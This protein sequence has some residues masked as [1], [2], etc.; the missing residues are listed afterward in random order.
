MLLTLYD[1]YVAD[2]KNMFTNSLKEEVLEDI[3]GNFFKNY[4]DI[5]EFPKRKIV[6]QVSETLKRV[7]KDGNEEEILTE[8]CENS[9][10]LQKSND[11]Y[12][13][14]HRTFYEYYVACKY[15]NDDKL[16]DE[17]INKIDN[18]KWEEVIR[19]YAGHIDSEKEDSKFIKKVWEKDNAFAIRCYMDMSKVNLELIKELLGNAK[20]EERIEIV[21]GLHEKVKEPLKVIET[22]KGLIYK[23][24]GERNETNGEVLYWIFDIL[25]NREEIKLFDEAKFLV[26]IWWRGNE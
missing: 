21:K 25:E 17:I 7:D 15:I 19:L 1:I 20:V 24:N 22:L 14:V 5:D 18:P 13:F 2:K 12:L 9:G 3:A 6:R 8:I 23:N 26:A 10:I 11:K 16:K 4:S